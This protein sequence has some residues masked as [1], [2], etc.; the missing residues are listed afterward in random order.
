MC[1]ETFWCHHI[2]SS[3]V[4]IVMPAV[5]VSHFPETLWVLS[6]FVVRVGDEMKNK[7]GRT[8]ALS[9]ETMGFVD[10]MFRNNIS[11]ENE[12]KQKE[13]R[14]HTAL[15]REDHAREKAPFLPDGSSCRCW[16]TWHNLE[17]RVTEE[18]GGEIG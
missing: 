10:L 4:L 12:K 6:H 7:K 17:G 11:H 16:P 18:R 1:Q 15:T 3:G 5:L 2:W 14:M 8:A 13:K 9:D